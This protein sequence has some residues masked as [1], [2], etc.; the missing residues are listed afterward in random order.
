MTDL[1]N[2]HLFP[3]Y[4]LA[5]TDDDGLRDPIFRTATLVSAEWVA[6]MATNA[7]GHEEAARILSGATLVS[8][9]G[10]DRLNHLAADPKH[11]VECQPHSY[12]AVRN[13]SRKDAA[14]HAARVRSMLSACVVL[15]G[16]ILKSFSP[17]PL[18]LAWSTVP[19]KIH[20]HQGRLTAKTRITLNEHTFLRP[21]HAS[22][23]EL[24]Q[25][26][27]DGSSMLMNDGRQWNISSEH[28]FAKV[29]CGDS[30]AKTDLKQRLQAGGIQLNEASN[31]LFP[32]AQIQMS[33][34]ALE[35]VLGSNSFS[36]LESVIKT[37]LPEKGDRRDL[38]RVLSA[39]NLFVHEGKVPSEDDQ[40]FLVGKSLLLGWVF[41]SLGCGLAE[42]RKTLGGYEAELDARRLAH[43]LIRVVDENLK[44]ST[45]SDE[46]RRAMSMLLTNELAK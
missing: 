36:K 37:F 41:L 44:D 23:A 38:R 16:G 17:S 13:D 27:R 35:I 22:K 6:G 15:T 43:Q 8:D 3:L 11:V 39:R 40:K 30:G 42:R 20:E 2:W 7:T 34:A 32:M 19:I 45:Q 4:G 12:I 5:I 31:T 24:R 18:S 33:V 14:H 46:I 21:E 1:R 26:W 29:L 28:A 10:G 25:S 9:L